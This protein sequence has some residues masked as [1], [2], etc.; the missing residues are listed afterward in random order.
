MAK[1]H[2]SSVKND[3]QRRL[4]GQPGLEEG[5]QEIELIGRKGDRRG[6]DTHPHPS[7]L[8]FGA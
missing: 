6:P 5:W 8:G 1:D 3:R 4:F 7:D 2:G